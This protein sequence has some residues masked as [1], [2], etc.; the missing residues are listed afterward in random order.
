MIN[1]GLTDYFY[2][3]KSIL[4]NLVEQR[5]AYD[6][7]SE[8]SLCDQYQK[9]SVQTNPLVR[10]CVYDNRYVSNNTFTNSVKIVKSNKRA[11]RIVTTFPKN[12]LK[13]KK[14]TWLAFNKRNSARS[15]GISNSNTK[16][17]LSC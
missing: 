12:N 10:I 11:V 7:S 2:N 1:I 9:V 13:T 6:L 14:N 5:L 15:P 16:E 3:I 8:F 4:R 17:I